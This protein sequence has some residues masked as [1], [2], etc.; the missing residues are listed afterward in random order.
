MHMPLRA[1]FRFRPSLSWVLLCVLLCTLWIAGGASRADALGQVAVRAVAILVMIVAILFGARPSFGSAK[2]VWALLG[3]S[4]ALAVAQIIPLPPELWSMLPG[5]AMLLE[6]ASASGQA[7]PWRPSSI[8]PGATVNA[9]ASLIIPAATLLLVTSL[10]EQE[11]LR[12]PGLMLCLIAAATMIGLMQFSGAGFE[13]PLINETPGMVSGTFANRNHF[14]LFS[15]I[16][17]LLVPVWMFLDGRRAR[18]RA[19]VGLGLVLLFSLTILATGSRAGIVLGALAL[20]IGLV[21]AR[22]GI[23]KELS[24]F[25][26]W[27]YPALIV[28]V[29]GVIF[30]LVAV[31]VAADRAVSFDRAF[32]VDQGTDMRSR[33]LSTVWA[34]IRAYFPVGS[35]LGSFDPIFRMHEPFALLKPTYFNHAHN[36]LL[37]VLLDAGLPGLLLLLGATL[38]W[39]TSS[40]RAWRG[41]RG[42]RTGMP[43]LGSATLLLIVIASGFDYPARTPMIMAVIILAAHWLCGSPR[44]KVSPAL[45][46]SGQHL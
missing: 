34:M 5:R 38:W 17:C 43:K 14:A 22:E 27:V 41:G 8:V 37:E 15:A 25:P 1:S 6:A 29:V 23:K 2:A 33:G 32:T 35:G 10:K 42:A 24:R 9:A 20:A 7:Q 16:G 36:D 31:S 46:V 13:N 28:A 4:I 19:P 30:L 12:V 11:R 18:W 21:L 39:V 26:A 44:P 3:T 40:L 45:P